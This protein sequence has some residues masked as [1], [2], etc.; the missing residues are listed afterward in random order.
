M[1]GELGL[2]ALTLRC[3]QR[4]ALLVK[5]NRDLTVWPEQGNTCRRTNYQ[6]RRALQV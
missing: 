5:A 3:S 2:C 4:L 6:H 1:Q